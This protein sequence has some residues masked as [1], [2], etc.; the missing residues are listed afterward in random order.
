VVKWTRTPHRPNKNKKYNWDSKIA[1]GQNK[2]RGRYEKSKTANLHYD[3]I[4]IAA[5][6]HQP[7]VDKTTGHTSRVFG[8]LVQDTDQVTRLDIPQ[9]QLAGLGACAQKLFVRTN[10]RRHDNKIGVY[11]RLGFE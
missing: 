8:M 11:Q 1:T 3:M 10:K 5:G 2:V 7:G 4:V 9:M 6:S